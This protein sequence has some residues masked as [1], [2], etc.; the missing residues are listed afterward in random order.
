[1]KNSAASGDGKIIHKDTGNVFEGSFFDNQKDGKG[2]L[3]VYGPKS[4][5]ILNDSEIKELHKSK[6]LVFTGEF[7][8]GVSSEQKADYGKRT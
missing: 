2:Q 3:K 8:F 7:S 5:K 4:G 1:M 6:P